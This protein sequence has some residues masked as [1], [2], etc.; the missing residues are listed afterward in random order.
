MP[1]CLE[2][3]W[4]FDP[5]T[6]VTCAHFHHQGGEG[7]PGRWCNC[8]VLTWKPSATPLLDHNGSERPSDKKCLPAWKCGGVSTPGPQSPV[9][10]ST[11][12]VAR[13]TQGGGATVW[14]SRGSPDRK[15]DG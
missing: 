2:V 8:L 15:S 5:R 3:R 11:T 7:H 13:G 12:R 10:T 14:F 6:A 4:G 1:A 9:L